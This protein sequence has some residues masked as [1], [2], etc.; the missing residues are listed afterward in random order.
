MLVPSFSGQTR[1]GWQGWWSRPRSCSRGRPGRT[2]WRGAHMPE[3]SRGRGTVIRAESDALDASEQSPRRLP[4]LCRAT[5]CTDL[6]KGGRGGTR[7]SARPENGSAAGDPGESGGIRPKS[8]GVAVVFGRLRL[9]TL[10]PGDPHELMQLD[11]REASASPDRGHFSRRPP[12][13]PGRPTFARGLLRC[14]G[15][16]RRILD[17]PHNGS[18]TPA[19][20]RAIGSVAASLL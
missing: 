16:H 6:S 13:P 18:P 2:C 7:F 10:P 11:A 17:P 9:D 15:P 4:P 19:T 5:R 8:L 1:G 14:R 3:S 12:F 20:D